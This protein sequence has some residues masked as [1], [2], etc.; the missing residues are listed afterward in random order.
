MKYAGTPKPLIDKHHGDAGWE[1][2]DDGVIVAGQPHGAPTWFPCN[3]R[4]DDKASYSIAVTTAADYTVVANGELVETKRGSSTVTWRYEQP[5]PMATY[6]ATVQIGR[7]DELRPTPARRSRCA[8]AVP[9]DVG[10][11][12]RG[13][14]RP[15]A[16]R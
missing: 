12:L 16:A 8:A 4:P 1:E 6:L 3:D 9:A 5:E 10:R 7:Y 13:R 2:L 11:R 14:L 15:A